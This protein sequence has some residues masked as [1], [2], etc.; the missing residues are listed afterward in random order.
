MEELLSKSGAIGLEAAKAIADAAMLEV[1]ST[2]VPHM[3]RKVQQKWTD[4]LLNVVLMF[5]LL[6]FSGS[7]GLLWRN[8]IWAFRAGLMIFLYTPNE[9]K[10]KFFGCLW[11]NIF[12]Y[13]WIDFE[14]AGDG[15]QDAHS[16]LGCR[17]NNNA[18]WESDHVKE[19][20]Y[21]Q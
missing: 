15:V 13:V 19:N 1:A 20:I 8:Y 17:H 4:H 5:R 6:L 21:I 18:L 9:M 11:L 7:R 2:N 10:K 16:L 3:V 14:G 12:H